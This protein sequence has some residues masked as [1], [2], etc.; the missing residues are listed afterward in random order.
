ML[1]DSTTS[2]RTE[3]NDTEFLAVRNRSVVQISSVRNFC[4]LPYDGS[5]THLKECF[6]LPF[7]VKGSKQVEARKDFLYKSQ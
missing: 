5:S 1:Y 3:H 7:L 6:N 2:H 4:P